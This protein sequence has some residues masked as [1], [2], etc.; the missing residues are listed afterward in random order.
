MSTLVTEPVPPMAK[1]IAA[2]LRDALAYRLEAKSQPVAA[3]ATTED[4]AC[5]SDRAAR[6]YRRV[7][8]AG[9][10]TLRHPRNV[11]GRS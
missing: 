10:R 6:H 1:R 5:A 8:L 11:K 9:L 7:A 2:C 3:W 4:L